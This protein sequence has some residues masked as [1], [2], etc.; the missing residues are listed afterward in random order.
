MHE[1]NEH[2]RPQ[3]DFRITSYREGFYQPNGFFSPDRML[4]DEA[5]IEWERENATI[6]GVKA[7]GK[8][9]GLFINTK[10]PLIFGRHPDMVDVVIDGDPDENG[11]SMP[12]EGI[13]RRH[14]GLQ[15]QDDKTILITDLNSRNGVKIYNSEGTPKTELKGDNKNAH[16]KIGDF[17]LFGGGSRE[18]WGRLIGFRVCQD[19]NGQVFLVKFNAQTFEDLLALASPSIQDKYDQAQKGE[20]QEANQPDFEMAYQ[21]LLPGVK[22]LHEEYKK[23]KHGPGYFKAARRLYTEI[24][25]TIEA[26]GD[27]LYDGD[28]SM[29]AARIGRIGMLE[30]E[31]FNNEGKIK[32]AARALE[33]SIILMKLSQGDA[34]QQVDDQDISSS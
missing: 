1:D 30:A 21:K 34:I 13:S 6:T 18:D 28:F 3:P 17:A 12:E 11:F 25:E 20:Q 32:E 23:D 15:V 5:I 27:K 24:F 14:F 7:W 26:V 22:N 19:P 4:S 2:L 16:L 8:G 9:Q 29:A 31:K 33:L 10:R